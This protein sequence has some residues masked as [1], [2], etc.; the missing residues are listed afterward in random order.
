MYQLADE[1]LYL[2]PTAEVPVTNIYANEILNGDELPS[3][4]SRPHR[5]FV[6][7]RARPAKTRAGNSVHQFDKVSGG[8]DH[9]T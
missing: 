1:T 7:K 9:T 8:A 6:V 2:I 3:C 5:A 4:S